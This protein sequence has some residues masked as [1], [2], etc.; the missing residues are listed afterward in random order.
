MFS[1]LLL[2]DIDECKKKFNKCLYL[3][4]YNVLILKDKGDYKGVEVEINEYINKGG[5]RSKEIDIIIMDIDNISD[6][7]KVIEFVKDNL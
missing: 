7:E 5:K 2:E 3:Y 1:E 4:F 6:Y